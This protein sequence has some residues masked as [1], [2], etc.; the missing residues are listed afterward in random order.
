[1]IGRGMIIVRVLLIMT[2]I[3][4]TVKG[5]FGLLFWGAVSLFAL[6][7]VISFG[8]N[9]WALRGTNCSGF[10]GYKQT[11]WGNKWRRKKLI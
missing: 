3:Y 8:G 9:L 10:W 7:F 5:E 11:K 2:M 4:Q 6:I 1:M